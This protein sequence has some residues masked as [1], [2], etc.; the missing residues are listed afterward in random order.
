[1]R[2]L[3]ARPLGRRLLAISLVAASV[4]ACATF[5]PAQPA[6]DL[7][8]IVGKWE[9]KG[10]SRKYGSFFIVLRIREDGIWQMTTDASYFGG[11]QFSG[12]AWVGEGKFESY[13]DTPQLRG[14]YTLHSGEGERWLIFMSEDGETTAELRASFR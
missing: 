6:K 12:K 13:S 14:T 4:C 2:H 3:A 8:S 11:R 7:K 1:M 5:P 10:M 9:G